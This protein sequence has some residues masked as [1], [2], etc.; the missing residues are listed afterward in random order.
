MDKFK[1]IPYYSLNLKKNILKIIKIFYLLLMEEQI[2]TSN[3]KKPLIEEKI[4]F[5][6]NNEFF[7][8]IKEKKIFP[9]FEVLKNYLDLDKNGE[10]IQDKKKPFK[11]QFKIENELKFYTLVKIKKEETDDINFSSAFL[12]IFCDK[13]ILMD[14]QLKIKIEKITIF[15]Y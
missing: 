14:E 10:I 9:F 3:D 5:E 8:K 13:I 2:V 12:F 15:Y 4:E 11:S 6:R 1:I 7:E